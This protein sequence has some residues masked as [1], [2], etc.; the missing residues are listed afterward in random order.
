MQKSILITGASGNLG[1]AVA[2]KFLTEG[3]TVLGTGHTQAGL[4]KVKMTSMDLSD[5]QAT[6][7]YL[8]ELCQQHPALNA[9]VLLVGGYAPGNLP[10]TTGSMLREMY[11]LNFETAYFV[12]HTLLPHFEAR[13]GGHFVLV[14][15]RAAFDAKAAQFNVAYGLSKSLLIA[16]AEVINVYGKDKGIRCS[17]IVPST[18]DTPPNRKDMPNADFSKWTTPEAIA[19]AIHFLFTDAGGQLRETVLKV[20]NEA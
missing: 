9:A 20:Y 13:G 10:N 6:Q 5:E 15:S 16:L 4:E 18:I 3:Y 14:A 1:Q 19:E 12:V 8:N 17:V 2:H 11:K 7:T